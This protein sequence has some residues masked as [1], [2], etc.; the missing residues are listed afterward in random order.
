M[1]R[2]KYLLNT[3]IAATGLLIFTACSTAESAPENT[4]VQ[5][6]VVNTTQGFGYTSLLK[7]LNVQAEGVDI[8]YI[9]SSEEVDPAIAAGSVHLDDTGDIGPITARGSGGQNVAIACTK[10]NN[11]LNHYLVKSDS[12]IESFGDLVGARVALH[13][14]SNHGLLFERLKNEHEVEDGAIEAVDITGSDSLTALLNDQVDAYS[15]LAP[16]ALDHLKKHPDLRSLEGITD[17]INNRYCLYTS[18]KTL[19]THHDEL[20]AYLTAVQETAL[21]AAENPEE[22]AQA[23]VDAGETQYDVETVAATFE[24]SGPGY[25]AIDDTFY[26]EYEPFVEE[27]ITAGFLDEPVDVRTVFVDDFKE[28][29]VK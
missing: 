13:Q 20:E 14:Q 21:W 19:E 2:N 10:P 6:L 9:T 17:R 24:A 27:L 25:Q 29:F 23:V 22:A 15:V 16:A 5:T 12:G 3:A 1:K 28:V 26:E 18:E 7:A 11:Q 4:E 8:E